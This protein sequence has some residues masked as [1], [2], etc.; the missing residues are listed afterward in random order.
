MKKN[1][2]T[3]EKSKLIQSSTN[4]Q[5][6]PPPR[7]TH[8]QSIGP[9]NMIA[10]MLKGKKMKVMHSQEKLFNR[11]KQKMHENPLYWHCV[12]KKNEEI[13]C[14]NQSIGL[15]KRLSNWSTSSQYHSIIAYFTQRATQIQW[16]NN[17]QRKRYKEIWTPEANAHTTEFLPG[18]SPVFEHELERLLTKFLKSITNRVTWLVRRRCERLARIDII[19][20]FRCQL[21]FRSRWSG[22]NDT[23]FRSLRHARL[24]TE[25][26]MVLLLLFVFVD[27]EHSCKNRCASYCT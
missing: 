18:N 1:E 23:W 24:Q 8:T 2:N 22:Y 19:V 4:I 11:V 9:K 17:M 6:P 12:V 10:H 27:E 21:L 5:P 7:C 26:K 15:I 16:R 25:S 13:K 3:K 20:L 14:E